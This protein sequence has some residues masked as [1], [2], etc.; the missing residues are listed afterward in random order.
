MS[1][2]VKCKAKTATLNQLQVTTKNNRKMIKGECAVCGITKSTFVTMKGGSLNS[3]IN[4]LPIEL[5]QFAEKGEDVPGGSFN[6]QQ[7]YSFC[8]PGTRYE[9]R[10]REGYKGIN[11]LDSMCKLHDKFY[12]ENT[13]TKV[14]NISDMALAHRADEIA[15]NPIY[16]AVQR[17][18]ANFIS[19]IMKTKA[20][21]GLGMPP[22]DLSQRNVPSGAKVEAW[23]EELANELH[24][25]VKRKFQ[26]RRVISYG[27]DDVWSC[28]LVEMQEWSKQNKGYRYML[29]VV[30][31]FSKFAW[32][33]KLLDKK[34]K[35]VLEAFEQIVDSSGRKP[36]HIWVDEGKE[37]YNKDMDAWIKE[38]NITRYSTH[39]EHKSAVVER[40]NRTLKTMMWKRFTAENTRNWID[41]LD[42]L[43]F[44]YNNTKHSTIKMTPTDAR[45]ASGGERSDSRTGGAANGKLM[46]NPLPYSAP[47]KPKFSVGD[48]V[49]ISRIKGIFEKGYL[50]NWSEALYTIHDVKATSPITY[51]LKDMKGEI[52]EGGF[53]TEELQRSKQEVFRIEKVLRKKQIN[54]V[55]HGLVK[56]LGY[57]K[58][59]N[60]WKPMYDIKKIN[61]N[62]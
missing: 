39:G 5:H 23:N 13:D 34:G 57:D 2:C 10:V 25:P 35:T 55:E 53:Y 47:P 27:V 11:E 38:N 20:K 44:K 22:A 40:F 45:G 32:S 12:N 30:D 37:F 60:E 51:I 6:D 50:P 56:W 28:D 21:F 42:K 29:N 8:G 16:D 19:G 4:N 54:G 9:Q 41:M 49:R 43:I 33:V 31:V 7:K 62:I 18:D 58:N 46:Y 17:K 61:I 48:Q 14:R 26:R 52:V 1:Y 36:K 15:N 3:F 24:A 59:F